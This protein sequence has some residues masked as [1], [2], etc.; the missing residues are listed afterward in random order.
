[1]NIAWASPLYIRNSY[2]HTSP[3][4]KD[5]CPQ[6][7]SLAVGPQLRTILGLLDLRSIQHRD[8]FGHLS[9]SKS[10]YMKKYLLQLSRVD[11]TKYH[12]NDKFTGEEMFQI[13]DERKGD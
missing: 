12:L 13:S 2:K 8:Y 3:F 9:L 10:V 6:L 1:M 5:L 4:F 7:A 11:I